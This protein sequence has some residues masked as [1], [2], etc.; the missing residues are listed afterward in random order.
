[1]FNLVSKIFFFV[2][3]A[4]FVF[5]LPAWADIRIEDSYVYNFHLYYDNGQLFADRDFEFKY[6]VIPEE[7]TPETFNTQFPFKGEII[8]LKNGVAAEF[9]FDPKR[10]NPD[11]LKGK[12]SVKAPYAPDGQKAVFYDSQGKILLTVFVSESSFCND[13]GTCNSDRGESEQTCP[14]DCRS[15]VPVP[16]PNLD[17]GFLS[18]NVVI[19]ITLVIAI[20]AAGGW[21]VWRRREKAKHIQ[22]NEFTDKFD[23]GIIN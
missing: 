22:E 7:F 18:A 2:S 17:K 15:A 16:P 20:L 6:D 14:N 5:L 12:I 19:L 1:M 13:D 23:Q 21:Y 10:G 9:L 3:V 8:N 11:F 4:V